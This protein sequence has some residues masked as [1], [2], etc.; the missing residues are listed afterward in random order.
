[1]T[2]LLA[3]FLKFLLPLVAGVLTTMLMTA[4]KGASATL[5]DES[6]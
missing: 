5:D 3:P 2:A 1:M 4:L 6:P